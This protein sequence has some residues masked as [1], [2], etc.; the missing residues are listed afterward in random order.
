MKL[1]FVYSTEMRCAHGSAGNS[2][3]LAWLPVDGD[4]CSVRGA[5]PLG[6]GETWASAELAVAGDVAASIFGFSRGGAISRA[7]TGKRCACCSDH[8]A[9]RPF[10]GLLV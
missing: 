2:V 9:A 5:A 4:G 10:S 1:K 7:S 3:A 6:S 8:L